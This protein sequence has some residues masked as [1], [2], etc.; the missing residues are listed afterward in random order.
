MIDN[1]YVVRTTDYFPNS[2]FDEQHFYYRKKLNNW[3]YSTDDRTETDD[4]QF[5]DMSSF[6]DSEIV[7]SILS[8]DARHSVGENTSWQPE[9]EGNNSQGQEP[10]IANHDDL[11]TELSESSEEPLETTSGSKESLRRSGQT[12]APRT[13][14]PGRITYGSTAIDSLMCPDVHTQLDI[15]DSVG[16]LSHYCANPGPIHCNSVTQIFRYLAETLE[17][18]ITFE[19]DSIDDLVGYTGSDWAGLKYRRKSTGGYAFLLSGGPV[20]HQPKQQP[21][22]ALFSTGAKYMATPEAG[23]E[24]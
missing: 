5:A 10:D 9:K 11:E 3:H 1:Q 6:D 16:V 17:L 2:T 14:Y 8:D 7:S 23:K 15:S 19:S 22:V 13:L 20:S 24:A 12:G 18:G 21:T 4:A